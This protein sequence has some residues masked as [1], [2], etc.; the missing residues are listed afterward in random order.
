MG[1]PYSKGVWKAGPTKSFEE[2]VYNRVF[3]KYLEMV[4]DLKTFE[5]NEELGDKFTGYPHYPG[6]EY[7]RYSSTEND[8][9]MFPVYSF[10]YGHLEHN[11]FPVLNKQLGILKMFLWK[12]PRQIVKPLDERIDAFSRALHLY[13]CV[14]KNEM[15]EYHPPPETDEVYP[16]R[17]KL[18]L[19]Y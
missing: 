7:D 19:V 1:N 14:K 18:W 3:E 4:R 12:E 11:S 15:I 17:D 9:R 8:Q 10:D 2:H 6:P 13:K 5:K 16:T